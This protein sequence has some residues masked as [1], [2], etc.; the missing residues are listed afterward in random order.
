MLWGLFLNCQYFVFCCS[1]PG[2]ECQH[3]GLQG[4]SQHIGLNSL[5]VLWASDNSLGICTLCRDGGWCPLFLHKRSMPPDAL[6]KIH[7][8]KE[9]D[10]LVVVNKTHS[11]IWGLENGGY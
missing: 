2:L 3:S 4:N 7:L 10:H 11:V 9:A 6:E 1:L 8:F 5:P